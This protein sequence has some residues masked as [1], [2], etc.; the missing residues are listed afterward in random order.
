MTGD[1]GLA[2]CLWNCVQG[3]ARQPIFDHDALPR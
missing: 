3:T 2:T 1:V